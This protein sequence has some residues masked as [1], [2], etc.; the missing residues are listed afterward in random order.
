MRK[1]EHT[2]ADDVRLKTLPTW[3]QRA[4]FQ[5]SYDGG[6]TLQYGKASRLRLAPELLSKLRLENGGK[7]M[8][9]FGP[10]SV[11]AWVKSNN[12]QTRIISY[13]LPA[14]IDLGFAEAAGDKIRFFR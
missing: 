11:D 14:L 2:G 5:Y 8:A 9:P 3:A 4:S 7:M 13:L 1:D 6:L 10:D 12:I